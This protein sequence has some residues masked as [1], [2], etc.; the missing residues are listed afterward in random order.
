M[1]SIIKKIIDSVLVSVCL[2]KINYYLKPFEFAVWCKS[3][4]LFYVVNK[5]IF[6]FS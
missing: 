4:Y 1:S 3:V 2:I 6:S 5:I